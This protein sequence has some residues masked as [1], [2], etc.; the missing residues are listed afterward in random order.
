MKYAFQALIELARKCKGFQPLKYFRE[1][2]SYLLRN[3]RAAN[4]QQAISFDGRRD[5]FPIK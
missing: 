5:P 2:V 1:V 3:T 4:A